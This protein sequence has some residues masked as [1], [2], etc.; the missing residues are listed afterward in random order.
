MGRKGLFKGNGFDY[1]YLAFLGQ[2]SSFCIH[3]TLS[4]E[5]G[6]EGQW[7]QSGATF[8]CTTP[9]FCNTVY[10]KGNLKYM[11]SAFLQDKFIS[12]I[13]S[14]CLV[15]ISFDIKHDLGKL[16]YSFKNLIP[17]GGLRL[18][19]KLSHCQQQWESADRNVIWTT[20][21]PRGNKDIFWEIWQD[22]Y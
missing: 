2:A 1:I 18:W 19:A 8:C 13:L 9:T 17:S 3:N 20:L 6:E 4:F 5:S 11:F 21:S 22:L 14:E 7:F 15:S 16:I 10:N 12:D